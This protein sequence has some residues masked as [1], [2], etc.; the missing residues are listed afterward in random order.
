MRAVRIYQYG[1][2]D[3]LRYEDNVSDPA[4]GPGIVLIKSVATSVNPI[5]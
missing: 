5:D 2:P 1:G 3:V 4:I